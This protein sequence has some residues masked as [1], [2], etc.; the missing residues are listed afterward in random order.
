MAKDEEEVKEEVLVTD[1]EALKENAEAAVAAFSEMW[2]S[3]PDF[4]DNC[5]VMD[6]GQ[7]RDAMGLRVTAE[8]DPWPTA[9]RLL[10]GMGFRW[11]WLGWQRVMYLRQRED[12]SPDTGWVDAEE[13][14]D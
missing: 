2:V 5:E 11:H 1:V 6:Q 7:L 12:R 14:E 13:V 4:T 9:E 3:M 10:L 8:G